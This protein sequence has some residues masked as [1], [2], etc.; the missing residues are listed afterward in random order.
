MEIKHIIH[1]IKPIYNE[2]SKVLILGTMPSVKS[3]ECNFYYGNEQ[4]RFWRALTGALG[5]DLPCTNE[6]KKAFLLEKGIALWD[7]I[8]QCDIAGSSDSS[9]KNAVPN[10]LTMIF[11]TA[12]IKAVF[13]TG[14]TAYKYY[15]RFNSEKYGREAICLPSPSPANARVKL[16]ELIKEYSVINTYL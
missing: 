10:D 4:N 1:T 8:A 11:D 3:R 15:C 9:I 5:C 6:G 2:N 7:V 13:T 14:K 12:D 16:D